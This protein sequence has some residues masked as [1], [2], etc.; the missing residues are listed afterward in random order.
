MS[1]SLSHLFHLPTLSWT[2]RLSRAFA[3]AV[4]KRRQVLMYRDLATLDAR[5]L[6]DLGI[7]RAQAGF[8]TDRSLLTG[9]TGLAGNLR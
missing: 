9:L 1:Q 6:K 4:A 5:M 3:R 2:E 8:V 7:S